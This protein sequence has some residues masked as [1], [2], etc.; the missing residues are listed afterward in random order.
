MSV[1]CNE[2]EYLSC[3]EAEQN[4]LRNVFKETI[5]H[6]CIKYNK[7][8]FHNHNAFEMRTKNHSSYIYPCEECLKE[9]NN[10]NQSVE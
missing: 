2:C 9:T 1:D 7:R 4:H 5:P 8:V 10:G 3:T 6:V